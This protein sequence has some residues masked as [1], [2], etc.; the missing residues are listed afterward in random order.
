MKF[1]PISIFST[2]LCCSFNFCENFKIDLSGKKPGD[3]ATFMLLVDGNSVEISLNFKIFEAVSKTE[4]LISEE[5]R[6]TKAKERLST[7]ATTTTVTTQPSTVTVMEQIHAFVKQMI[8]E[9]KTAITAENFVKL[10][11]D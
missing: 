9:Q 4:A 11:Q 3:S 10:F 1:T 7:E 8:R 5:E 2:L 6:E